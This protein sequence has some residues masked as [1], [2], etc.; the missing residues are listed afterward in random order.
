MIHLSLKSTISEEERFSLERS[1]FRTD[2]RSMMVHDHIDFA[3]VVWVERGDGIHIVNNKQI[4]LKEG[5]IAF[6]RPSDAH[7]I[8][9]ANTEDSLTIVNLS[10]YTETLDHFRNR[11]FPLSKDF[12]WS[13]HAMPHHVS[14]D[15]Q[16]L[17]FLERQVDLLLRKPPN[18]FNLDKLLIT[19]FDLAMEKPIEDIGGDLPEWL[20]STIKEFSRQDNL[21]GGAARFVQIACRSREYVNR[22]VKRRMGETLSEMVNRI[23][24]QYAAYL[25]KTTEEKITNIADAA[26]FQNLGYFY[27]VFNHHYQSTPSEY[28]KKHRAHLG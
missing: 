13:K 21:A 6:I 23:R 9:S 14:L 28:R 19:I 8:S 15:R 10:F 25:L 12:F 16:K 3:E 1:T 22:T 18:H 20:R 27:R 24:I 4:P 11:Y 2:Y 5:D 7:A 17:N 26:G